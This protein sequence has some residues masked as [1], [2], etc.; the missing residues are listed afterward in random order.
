ENSYAKDIN[1]NYITID[2]NEDNEIQMSEALEVAELFLNGMPYDI[3]DLQG[4]E[5]FTNIKTLSAYNL[6]IT[7][8]D[9]TSLTS[10][11]SLACSNMPLSTLNITG[12]SGLSFLNC[13]NTSLQS[14]D[15]TGVTNLKE[16]ICNEI[17]TL[18]NLNFSM[19]DSIEKL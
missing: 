14:I 9:L 10:L 11:E 15:F 12:I 4:I 1:D 7:S 8:L 16:L 5:H 6:F 17:P 13:S 18:S 2:A 3:N 19:I